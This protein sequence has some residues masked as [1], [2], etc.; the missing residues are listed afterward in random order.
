[1]YLKVFKIISFLVFIVFFYFHISFYVSDTFK[2]HVEVS[3]KNHDQFIEN[4]SKNLNIIP[5]KLEYKKFIDNSE[6]FKKIEKQPK[7]WELLK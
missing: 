4:F 5:S 3:R 6:Y 7:F 1:M 2:N